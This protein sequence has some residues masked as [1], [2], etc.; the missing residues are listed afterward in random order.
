L[1]NPKKFFINNK[2]KSVKDMIDTNLKPG[3]VTNEDLEAAFMSTKPSS[4]LKVAVY[5]KWMSNYGSI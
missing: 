3:L 2:G 4:A 5:E 1:E